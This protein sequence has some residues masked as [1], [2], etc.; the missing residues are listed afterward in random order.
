MQGYVEAKNFV[1]FNL[2]FSLFPN[3]EKMQADRR[4]ASSGAVYGYRRK[5]KTVRCAANFPLFPDTEKM[6][7]NCRFAAS[8]AVYGY[9]RKYKTVRCAANFPL[10]P[11]TEKMQA[12]C[13]FA[14]SGA[15]H[16]YRPERKTVRCAA[17]FS[18]QLLRRN[19]AARL[20]RYSRLFKEASITTSSNKYFSTSPISRPVL[21][22]SFIKSLPFICSC[23]TVYG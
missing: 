18:R 10:F 1:R 16:G 9:R 13:R 12:N 15:V 23:D 4:F 19:S 6:Q 8:G 2:D 17:D 5:Y 21:K 14:A 7:A 11:D 3:L 20:I 22:P